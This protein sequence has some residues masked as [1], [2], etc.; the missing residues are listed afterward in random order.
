[1]QRGGHSC[2]V[3]HLLY[4]GDFLLWSLTVVGLY[5]NMIPAISNLA[6]VLDM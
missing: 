6:L 4:N 1:M 2:R 3:H 5:P